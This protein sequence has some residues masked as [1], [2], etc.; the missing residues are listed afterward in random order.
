MRGSET[1]IAEKLP[2]IRLPSNF[3]FCMEFLCYELACDAIRKHVHEKD[4]Q[5]EQRKKRNTLNSG[6]NAILLFMMLPI[7]SRNAW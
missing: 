4:T 5:Q 2:E 3:Y 7:E 6:R 1:K